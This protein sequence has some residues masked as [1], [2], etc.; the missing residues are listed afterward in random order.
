MDPDVITKVCRTKVR[1]IRKRIAATRSDLAHSM[2][3][4]SGAF[5]VSFDFAF[6]ELVSAGP[7]S[8]FSLTPP[9]FRRFFLAIVA[10]RRNLRTSHQGTIPTSPSSSLTSGTHSLP[11]STVTSR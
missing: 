7:P 11:S 5:G 3:V 6:G 8:P 10:Y 4:P 2:T 9:L 1:M